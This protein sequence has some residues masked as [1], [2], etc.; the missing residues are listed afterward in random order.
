[1]AQVPEYSFVSQVLQADSPVTSDNRQFAGAAI[2][3]DARQCPAPFT[4]EVGPQ[5][6]QVWCMST[7][8]SLNPNQPQQNVAQ[9]AAWELL[10]SYVE[11]AIAADSAKLSNLTNRASVTGSVVFP[12]M[13]ASMSTMQLVISKIQ[14]L[15]PLSTSFNISLNVSLYISRSF[16][17]FV[18]VK[19]L[20]I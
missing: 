16:F 3:S 7:C 15:L 11:S 2:R 18:R 5:H 20:P 12:H 10:D 1:M 6:C 19:E 4:S 13:G 9:M 17:S 8:P 14:T